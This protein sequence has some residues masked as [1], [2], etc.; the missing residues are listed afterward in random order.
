M[1]YVYVLYNAKANKI[2]VGQT[3]DLDRRLTEHNKKKG[4]HYTAKF[5]GQWELIYQEVLGDRLAAMAR[6]KQLK[7]HQGR[8]FL[9]EKFN[10]P[11]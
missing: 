8:N 2:Y 10:I 4:N 11:G 5:P 3:D 9:K 1:Y 6:E 7:S